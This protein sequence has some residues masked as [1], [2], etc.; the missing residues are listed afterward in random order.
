MD[1]E[2]SP[3]SSANLASSRINESMGLHMGL[4]EDQR[5]SSNN[6]DQI[7]TEQPRDSYTYLMSP[8]EYSKVVGKTNDMQVEIIEAHLNELSKLP[9]KSDELRATQIARD[10]IL[11]G[12]DNLNTNNHRIS[13]EIPEPLDFDNLD[14]IQNINSAFEKKDRVQN[15][16]VAIFEQTDQGY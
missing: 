14:R 15:N 7:Q 10:Q 8:S 4:P 6:I 1:L 13:H 9:A 16:Q 5:L 3:K 12:L 2:Q 11:G